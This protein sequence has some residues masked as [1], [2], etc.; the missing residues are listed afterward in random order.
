MEKAGEGM[1]I[2]Q[3]AVSVCQTMNFDRD[4]LDSKLSPH[5]DT[6]YRQSSVITYGNFASIFLVIMHRKSW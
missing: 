4:V 3:R 5:Q 2:K 1:S 6:C